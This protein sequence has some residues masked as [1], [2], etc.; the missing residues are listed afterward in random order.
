MCDQVGNHED[1]VSHKEAQ[2]KRS[3]DKG[4]VLVIIKCEPHC[5]KTGPFVYAKTKAQISYGCKK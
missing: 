4:L 3:T 2:T 5:E 1:R